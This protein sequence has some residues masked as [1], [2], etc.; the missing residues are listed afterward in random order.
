MVQKVVIGLIEHMGDIVACEPV[1]RQLRKIYK[2]SEITWM[3]LPAYHELLISNPNIDRVTSVTCLTEWIKFTKHAT[4]NTIIFDLHVNYRA[5]ECCRIPLVKISGNQTITIHN[6]YDHGSLLEAF[7]IG[8]GLG[9]LST[10]PNVYI[11]KDDV[12]NINLLNIPQKFI[13]IHRH[14][15]DIARD[16]TDDK[17]N[18]LLRIITNNHNLY[19]VEVGTASAINNPVSCCNYIDMRGK[20]TILE[21]AEIIRRSALFVG[22]D[23]GPAHIANAV[24]TPGVILLGTLGN[25]KKYMPYSGYYSSNCDSV[26]IIRNVYGPAKDITV[27]DVY[28]GVKYAMNAPMSSPVVVS[29]DSTEVQIVDNKYSYNDRTLVKVL[30]F[31]LPQF[32]PIHENNMAWGHGFS[33][34]TNIIHAKPL[35]DGHRQ[36]I[37]PGELGYYDLRSIDI[38]K[39]QCELASAH[40]ISGFCFYY[41]FMNGKRLLHK[42]LDN[43][44][45]SGIKFPFCL[46]FANH[47]WTKKWDAG[48]EEIIAEQLHGEYADT[49]F[50]KSLLPIFSDS[51]YIKIDGKPLLIIFMAHLIQDIKTV[52]ESWRNEVVNYGFTGLYLVTVDNWNGVMTNPKDF[53]FDATY[54]MPSNDFGKY[55]D[56]SSSI[57]GL[58]KDF[59]GKIID[60]DEFAKDYMAR[61]FPVRKIFKTVM[62][63][64]DN[65]PRYK[66][67][68]IITLD[69]TKLESYR[70]W[71]TSAYIDTYRRYNGD[72]RILFLHSWNEWAEGT[73]IEPDSLHGRMR[74]EITRKSINDGICAVDFIKT[75]N[76]SE[77]EDNCIINILRLLEEKDELLYRYIETMDNNKGVVDLTDEINKIKHDYNML[78][79]SRSMRITSPLRRVAMMLRRFRGSYTF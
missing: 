16:W 78:I 58:I 48:N 30:A 27:E 39:S 9:K 52:T 51:R 75:I 56:I 49:F 57:G 33:E 35:F 21:M 13:V 38:I 61:P 74:L 28:D 46:I 59:T 20:T 63:P 10:H 14:S 2:E 65:T 36:P 50:I 55:K 8:A 32:H 77:N 22:I 4:K 71:L 26:R 24:Y 6:W 23:S 18:D 42:P 54:E 19:V 76:T 45:N 62:A 72:E 41:Y 34:W 25:F 66:N 69:N 60:Y 7:S 64:W 53:G 44:M 1:S 12:D 37:E 40:G 43:F 15:N 29:Q 79:N 73:Y 11:R 5:C 67:R 31:Y 3:A 70:R 68:A 17:W 47:N